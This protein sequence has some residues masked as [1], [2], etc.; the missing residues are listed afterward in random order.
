MDGQQIQ[1]RIKFGDLPYT[2]VQM[3]YWVC[4]SVITFWFP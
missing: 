1:P 4:A 2:V 3:H